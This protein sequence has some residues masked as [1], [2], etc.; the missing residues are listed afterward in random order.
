MDKFNENKHV[1]S[2]ESMLTN[3]D[4]MNFIR[5]KNNKDLSSAYKDLLQKFYEF[6]E[7]LEN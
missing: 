7:Q 1:D 3:V 6:V 5:D 2:I 4:F